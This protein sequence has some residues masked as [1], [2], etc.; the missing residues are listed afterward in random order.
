MRKGM[1]CAAF[2]AAFLGMGTAAQSA[3]PKLGG[4]ATVGSLV[5]SVVCVGN[6]RNYRNFNHCW[7][8]NARRN[9]R[10]ANYCSRICPTAGSR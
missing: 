1:L 4:P 5:Q 6:R 2:A 3:M 7:R 8:V 10:N 9:P